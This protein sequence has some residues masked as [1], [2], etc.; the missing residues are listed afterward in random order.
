MASAG[1]G[2]WY[3]NGYIFVSTCA[4]LTY[5]KGIGSAMHGMGEK[6]YFLEEGIVQVDGGSGFGF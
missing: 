6:M 1:N 4:I 2:M 3:Y 5:I